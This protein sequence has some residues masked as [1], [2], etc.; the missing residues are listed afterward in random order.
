MPQP[1]CRRAALLL[2]ALLAA[3]GCS[4]APRTSADAAGSAIVQRSLNAAQL[5]LERG[6]PEEAL[7]EA[8]RA[9]R[10]DPRNGRARIAEAQALSALG[11]ANEAGVAFERAA[12]LAPGDAVVLNAWGSWMCGAGKHIEALDAF[13]R[14]LQDPTYRTPVQALANA[15]SCA[16]EAG[17][18]ETAEMNFR[19]ALGMQPR[20]AQSLVG[21]ARIELKR[22]NALGARGFL[23][24]REA[25]APLAQSELMLGME[26][27]DAAGDRRAVERYRQQLS[28][29]PRAGSADPSTA[30]GSSKQ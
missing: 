20:H 7:V 2:G 24:R 27:E 26:I 25:L 3:G 21:M 18:L 30:T 10:A 22:G 6:R 9:V 5:L 12:V 28:A 19:A 15:G 14:A 17:R 23:Q 16:A 1:D 4:T 11:R 29:P 13:A 8:Q